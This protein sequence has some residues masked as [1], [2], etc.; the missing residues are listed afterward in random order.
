MLRGG[1]RPWSQTMVSE[2][3]RPWGRG[4]SG[5]SELSSSPPPVRASEPF[6]KV[7][8]NAFFGL[9]PHP[10]LTGV[11]R[12][13]RARNP[14]KSARESPGVE[15]V[16]KTVSKQSPEPQNS[17]FQDSGD[18][19]ETILDPFSTPGPEGPERLSRRLFGVPG[20]K[21]KLH[22]D[23]EQ[24]ALLTFSSYGF[25][26]LFSAIAVFLALSGKVC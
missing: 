20:P 1:L 26:S 22:K 19:F 8:V 16:P 17:L 2:G 18:C 24:R 12:A 15:K 6:D 5:D 13:L 14:K 3:A 4:R 7:R 21:P 10:P 11:S 23:Q 25:S 9:R